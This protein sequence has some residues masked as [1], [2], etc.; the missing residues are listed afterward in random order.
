MDYNKKY[1]KYKV[2]YLKA[3]KELNQ[4]GGGNIEDILKKKTMTTRELNI[5]NKNIK[6]KKY[7]KLILDKIRTI[8]KEDK[9]SFKVFS[10]KLVIGD[11]SN[12][13]G[14]DFRHI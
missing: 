8:K 10:S 1:L 13:G 9:G 14:Y 12:N 5:L 6:D 7:K 3:S 4:I 2:K 11:P